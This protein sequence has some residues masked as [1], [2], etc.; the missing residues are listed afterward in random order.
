LQPADHYALPVSSGSIC[1]LPGGDEFTACA[2][3]ERPPDRESDVVSVIYC[4]ARKPRRA[5][6]SPVAAEIHSV[7]KKVQPLLAILSKKRKFV[8]AITFSGRPP[9]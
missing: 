9:S 2:R 1:P 8:T 5:S 6:V 7:R 4:H 3:T